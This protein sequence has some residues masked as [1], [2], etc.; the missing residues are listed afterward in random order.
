MSIVQDFVF[1]RG[2]KEFNEIVQ[3]LPS[4]TLLQ[5][6]PAYK[7]YLQKAN[8]RKKEWALSHRT[9]L[10]TQGNLGLGQPASMELTQCYRF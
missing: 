2:T 10:R 6:Y 5:K 8:D 9:D 3:L 1:A 7:E 4:D